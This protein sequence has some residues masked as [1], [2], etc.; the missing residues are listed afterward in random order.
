MAGE[1]RPAAR[2]GD[3]VVRYGSDLVVRY[4]SPASLPVLGYQPEDLAG[5]AIADLAHPEDLSAL[6]DHVRD[7]DAAPPVS[8]RY[9]HRDGHWVWLEAT[10]DP[11]LG[12]VRL[13]ARDVDERRRVEEELRANQELTRLILATAS[14]AFLS[15]DAGGRIVEWNRAAEALLG[16]GRDEAIGR[17]AADVVPAAAR[18]DFRAEMGRRLAAAAP[19]GQDASVGAAVEAVLLHRDGHQVPVEMTMWALAGTRFNCLARD[20]TRRKQTER[21]L[22]EARERALEASRLKSRFL[23]AMS[24]EIRTPMNGVLGLAT[25]LLR[26]SLDETQ[27][28]YADG[29]RIAGEALL[30]VLNDVL[31]LSKLEAGRVDLERVDLDLG[32]V[33]DEVVAL[34]AASARAK[35]LPVVGDRADLPAVLGDP[36]RV[37]QVLLN[38]AANAVK[39]TERGEVVVRVR[40]ERVEPAAV[41]ARLEVADSGIGIRPE[42]RE[43]IFDAFTQADASTTRRF[44][45]TGLGLSIS[46]HLVEAMG[47]RIGVVSEPGRGSVFWCEI[48]FERAAGRPAPAPSAPAPSAP[49]SSPA[50]SASGSDPG[51]ASGRGV[52]LVAEDNDINQL[53]A[54]ALLAQLGYEADVAGDGRVALDL[55]SRRRYDAVLMDC[56]MPEM[57]GYAAT[58]ELRRR[59]AGGPRT[60]VIALTAGARAEDRDRCLAAGMDDHL[61]KPLGPAALAEALN[62]WVRPPER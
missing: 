47:G 58:A 25:L 21:A 24:H 44:G 6:A 2:A 28:R 20:I 14:D 36:G 41:V 23:A 4:V 29:I 12:T 37:R 57:D 62:R 39:F 17:D 56:Q 60:P 27:H 9:R 8:A 1:R 35:N 52:V 33:V 46:R 16:W 31:D 50:G 38:L 54:T 42:D 19:P 59:E 5:T 22:T 53:V 49:A 45:G 32:A 30:T 7:L 11:D 61:A 34:V 55:V 18:A 13:A 15:A 26:T 3:V 10:A 48:P 43:R 40:A 51:K